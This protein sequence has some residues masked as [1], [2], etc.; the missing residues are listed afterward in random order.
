MR[1]KLL[2]IGLIGLFFLPSC[3]KDNKQNTN[4]KRIVLYS[5]INS[6]IPLSS[7]EYEYDSKNRISKV[8]TPMYDANGKVT[9]TVK[10]NTYE[11]NAKGQLEKIAYYNANINSPNGFINTQNFTYTYDDS[12]LKIKELNSSTNEYSLFKY[13]NKL[14][15]K[16]EYYDSSNNLLYYITN[17]YNS[18]NELIKATQYS[19][20][21]ESIYVTTNTYVNGLN[22]LTEVYNKGN[23]LREVKKSYDSS[24]NLIM[25]ESNESEY[26]SQASFV[27]KYEYIKE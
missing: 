12:G 16:T 7:D 3:E 19:A 5:S 1:T 24:N 26:S 21:N 22:T 10:Y 18:S 25:I 11:Y 13:S 9:G 23:K 27:L 8:T 6:Q 17:E 4:L 2:L 20:N 15:V 14:L